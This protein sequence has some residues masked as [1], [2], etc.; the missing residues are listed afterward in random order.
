M[1]ER[2]RKSGRKRERERK[3]NRERENLRVFLHKSSKDSLPMATI[4][5]SRHSRFAFLKQTR[6]LSVFQLYQYHCKV[7]IIEGYCGKII[8]GIWIA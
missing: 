3:K 4:R 7:N 5:T 1:R 2:E 6:K 8:S